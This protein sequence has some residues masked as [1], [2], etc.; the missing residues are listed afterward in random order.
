MISTETVVKT[1]ETF[2]ERI[3]AALRARKKTRAWLSKE[4][5]VPQPTIYSWYRTPQIR[6]TIE[7]AA[8][9][10]VALNTGL[11]YLC[12][13]TETPTFAGDV[14]Q[15]DVV[16]LDEEMLEDVLASHPKERA[17]DKWVCWRPPLVHGICP[18]PKRY[19]VATPL[20]AATIAQE[21][22][23]K[24]S[25]RLPRLYRRWYRLHGDANERVEG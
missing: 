2:T 5:G 17:I 12:G 13:I 7:S 25:G 6:P 4:S 18:V 24:I 11:D 23:T 16:L 22:I 1:I 15:G 20:Q 21:I 9:V 19:R 10:A 8:K 3:D 14:P